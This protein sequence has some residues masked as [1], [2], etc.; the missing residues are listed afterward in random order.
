[1]ASETISDRIVVLKNEIKEYAWGSG[2]F[3][4]EL[5]EVP[6][7]DRPQ[8]E[9]WLGAHP[10]GPSLALSGDKQE[11]LDELIKTDPEGML[12]A[13]VARRFFGRLPFLFKVLAAARPLSIQAHPNRDQALRGFDK[14]DAMGN[15]LD[16]PDRNYKDRNHKPELICALTRMWALKGFR[17]KEE[18]L[19]LTSRIDA[20]S[21]AFYA[22]QL[23]EGT[24]EEGLRNFFV[25]LLTMEKERQQ[26]LIEEAMGAIKD[27]KILSP[28]VDWMKKLYRD[29]PGDIGVLSPL[30][31]NVISLEPGEAVYIS[32]GE[33][34]GYLE[35]A[36]LEIMAN[37]D[38]V[39]RG[40]LT[41]KHV[42]AAELMKILDF[43][44]H[45]P[46]IIIPEATG[47]ESFYR[48]GS[49]EFV[50]SVISLQGKTAT[51]FYRSANQRSAEIIIC[52]AGKARV[53]DVPTG[54]SIDLSKGMS[55]F[56]PASIK[57]YVIRGDATLYKAA[58]P[59]K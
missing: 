4:P 26:S 10:G 34:H 54:D 38:N 42:D 40:G 43:T 7:P 30:F 37:S 59:L 20:P 18:I 35:G 3:I 46:K 57:E 16:S 27:M 49:D 5:L 58:T 36:G 8:A 1:M 21:I 15:P 19:D 45:E 33:L 2:T 56:I 25:S 48:T 41:S 32:S 22:A 28:A 9:M 39:I 53:E 11:P 6:S 47:V 31:L 52:T 29:Y 14:E 17:K 13:S 55:I 51:P 12:G 24:D 50:L 44:P 23:R